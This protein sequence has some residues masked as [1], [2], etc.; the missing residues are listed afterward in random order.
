M[1]L[2][3]IMRT[4]HKDVLDAIRPNTPETEQKLK[5]ILEPFTKPVCS[6]ILGLA[7]N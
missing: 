3:A 1:S 7:E 6:V 5:G 2:L 4:D